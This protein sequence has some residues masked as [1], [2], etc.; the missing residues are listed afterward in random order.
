MTRHKVRKKKIAASITGCI[1]R[2]RKNEA[3]SLVKKI[4]YSSFRGNKVTRTG[5]NEE[6]KTLE[7][8]VTKLGDG[9]S[10]PKCGLHINTAWPWLCA[11]PD[12]IVLY[13]NKPAGLVEVKNLHN[14]KL[15]LINAAQKEKTFC[16]QSAIDKAMIK[17]EKTHVYYHQVQAQANICG[18]SMMDF[19]DRATNPYDLHIERIYP[20]KQMWKD[21]WLPKL[22]CFYFK[23]L[24]PELAASRNNKIPGI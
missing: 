21:V 19:V 4:N 12:G 20:D 18:A 13:E 7:D 5:L 8:Y 11:S 22:K 17:L 2:R 15:T 1:V 10:I 9:W 6:E 16:L 23:N 24:L 3:T 14:K